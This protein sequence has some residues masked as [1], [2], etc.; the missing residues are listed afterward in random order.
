MKT[1]NI[2]NILD[3]YVICALWSSMD[4]DGEPLDA[5]FTIDDIDTK[6]LNCMRSDVA[7]FVESNADLLEQSGL[8]D[9]QIGHDFW[10]TRNHHG[11]GFWDRGLPDSI[12]DALTKAAHS[13]GGVDLYVGHNGYVYAMGE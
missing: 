10:L 2:E 4:E 1:F 9:Q 5:V 11:A 13:C 8:S 7:G 12:G 6:T 3:H